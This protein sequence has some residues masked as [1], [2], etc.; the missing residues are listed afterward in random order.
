MCC[1]VCK[2]TG[3]VCCGPR[4]YLASLD[5]CCGMQ[6]TALVL[7]SSQKMLDQDHPCWNILQV[8]SWI[9]LCAGLSAK[10]LAKGPCVTASV[11]TVH[12]LRFV[13]LQTWMEFLSYQPDCRQKFSHHLSPVTSVLVVMQEREMGTLV[14]CGCHTHSVG[15]F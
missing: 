11:D 10:M 12:F 5:L 9:D 7:R 2:T 15:V 3:R 6:H 13:W 14:W 4:L 8:L 1:A